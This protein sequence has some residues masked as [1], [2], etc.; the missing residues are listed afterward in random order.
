MK[1]DAVSHRAQFSGPCSSMYTVCLSGILFA[2]HNVRY[3]IYADDTQ[4]YVQCPPNDHTDASRQ[5]TECVE[6]LRRWL[7]DN[8]L[9]LNEDKT[10]AILFRSSV[11]I[12]ST[13]NIGGSVA[14]VKLTVRDIGVVLDNRLDMASQVS[15][16]CRSAYYHLF[17]IAKIR[18][19]LTIVACNTLV[20]ALVISRLDYGN[21]LLYGITDRLLHSLDMI[22]HSA[23]RIIMC[24]KR[25][26]R[27][28]IMAV[29]RQLHWLPVKWRINYNRPGQ[30]FMDEGHISTLTACRGPHDLS[31]SLV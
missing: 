16:V 8:R 12:I 20:H 1:F 18:A 25:H 15:S 28:S 13:I 17:R 27:Q 31:H 21:A 30:P 29:L 24:T 22:Q 9:L 3:H 14:Q 10:E 26:D 7:A 23:V 11:Q 19:S 5:I 4:L 2:K 6:D